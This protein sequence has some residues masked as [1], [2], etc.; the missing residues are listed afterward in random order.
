LFVNRLPVPFTE[1]EIREFFGEAKGGIISVK[2]TTDHQKRQKSSAFVEFGDEEAMNAGLSKHAETLRDAT[3]KVVIAED[4]GHPD[5]PS[6]RGSMRGRGRGAFGR[7]G[8]AAAVAAAAGPSGRPRGSFSK[9]GETKES[10]PQAG[11]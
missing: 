3:P 2:W 8:V 1:D 10:A 6:N 4:R 7:G 11:A 9:K 5:G